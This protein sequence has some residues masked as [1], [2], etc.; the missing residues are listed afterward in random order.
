MAVSAV[1]L[2]FFHENL[3]LPF[4]PAQAGPK[5]GYSEADKSSS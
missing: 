1:T 5:T 3:K 4:M 2:V